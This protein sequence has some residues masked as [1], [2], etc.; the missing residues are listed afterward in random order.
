MYVVQ[1]L[2]IPPPSLPHFRLPPPLSLLLFGGDQ[3][4]VCVC[5]KCECGY[6]AWMRR[7]RDDCKTTKPLDLD[8]NMKVDGS[9]LARFTVYFGFQR[10]TTLYAARTIERASKTQSLHF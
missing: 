5:E 6:G 4:E 1:V 7:A 8:H 2:L 9:N 3:G 10:V